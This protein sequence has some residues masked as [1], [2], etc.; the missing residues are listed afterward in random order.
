MASMIFFKA[1]LQFVS[2]LFS[3]SLKL[4][5]DTWQIHDLKVKKSHVKYNFSLLRS[6]ALFL[7]LHQQASL[8]SSPSPLPHEHQ[9]APKSKLAREKGQN[10]EQYRQESYMKWRRG[11]EQTRR[12]GGEDESR[13]SEDLARFQMV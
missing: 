4:M 1:P 10:I 8:S 13:E 9:K 12:N 2:L 5:N 6:L 7:P 11:T 3:P